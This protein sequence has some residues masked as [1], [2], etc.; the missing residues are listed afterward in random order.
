ML[1]AVLIH[2]HKPTKEQNCKMIKPKW[3]DFFPDC[4]TVYPD[5]TTFGVDCRYRCHCVN[6]VQCNDVTGECPSGCQTGWMG[7]ACQYRKILY[8]FENMYLLRHF[9]YL[10]DNVCGDFYFYF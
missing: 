8:N 7:P 1:T 9:C 4:S 5:I 2:K 3:H 6:D 10:D